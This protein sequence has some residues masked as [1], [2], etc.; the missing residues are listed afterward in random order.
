MLKVETL[1]KT[2]P[3]VTLKHDELIGTTQLSKVPKL[4]SLKIRK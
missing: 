3:T 1:K 4:P 2:E